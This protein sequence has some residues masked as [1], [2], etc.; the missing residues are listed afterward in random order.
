MTQWALPDGDIALGGFTEG[1]GNANAVAFDELD[2]GFG[3]GRGSGSGPDDA[4]T[5]WQS[6]NNPAGQILSCDISNVTQPAV[7]TGHF[8]RVRWQKSASGGRTI[9]AT[10]QLMQGLTIV[11]FLGDLNLA[12][13]WSTLGVA[14]MA[15]ANVDLITDYNTLHVEVFFADV[16]G[17]GPGRRGHISAIEFEVPDAAP[18]LVG[19][20][21]AAL[22]QMAG[23]TPCMIEDVPVPY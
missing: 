17:S 10:A 11:Q 13:G 14:E 8:F 15:Q 3:A 23:D 22:G 21:V 4:T 2:E 9:E 19:P 16:T 6:P 5:F 7:D 1:A 18:P 20:A 12:N